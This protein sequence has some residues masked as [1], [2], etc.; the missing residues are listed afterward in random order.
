MKIVRTND[1]ISVARLNEQV[2]NLH[3][4][5]YP[6]IF[7]SYDFESVHD[8]FSKITDDENHYF[9]ICEIDDLPVGYIWFEEIIKEE[10]AFSVA[11]HLIYVHQV[12][13]N[14]KWRG[15]GV[16]KKL[17]DTALKLAEEKS[18]KRI[19]LDYY[20]EN[21]SAK[22]I[23]EKMGFELEREVTFLNR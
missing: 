8:Y 17:F 5:L 21:K 6:H 14:K 3:H 13:V 15:E 9:V 19:G 22:A 20:V 4:E 18:I 12:S 1:A 2:Q 7:K 10:N 11:K 23:Y 16:G